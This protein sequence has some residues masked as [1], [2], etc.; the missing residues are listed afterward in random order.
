M[1]KSSGEF[2]NIWSS[3]EFNRELEDDFLEPELKRSSAADVFSAKKLRCLGG[4]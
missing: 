4:E 3:V 2:D 1:S